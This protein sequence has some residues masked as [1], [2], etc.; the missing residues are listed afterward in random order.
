M[1][2]LYLLLNSFVLRFDDFFFFVFEGVFI[3]EGPFELV[4]SG[5]APIPQYYFILGTL[6]GGN[7]TG[8]MFILVI[9][10]VAEVYW[11]ISIIFMFL[12][13]IDRVIETGRKVAFN[14]RPCS[15]DIFVV[16]SF[17]LEE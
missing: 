13:D 7:S 1:H 5:I 6:N 8:H 16:M 9:N 12:D 15:L 2:K 17:V 3:P 10:G 14:F 4:V 11:E